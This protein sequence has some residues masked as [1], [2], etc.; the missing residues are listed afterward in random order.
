MHPQ[1]IIYVLLLV[2][3]ASASIAQW[4]SLSRGERFF[5]VLLMITVV[6]ETVAHVM[7]IVY[8][9]NLP[10]YH[11]YSPVELALTS[12]YLSDTTSF[13]HKR[14]MGYWIAGIAVG[15]GILNTT[16]FQPLE[17]FNTYYLLFESTIIIVLCLLSFYEM[18]LGEEG[19]P[20]RSAQ[21]WIVVFLLLYWSSTFFSWGVYNL[22]PSP[23][24]PRFAIIGTI[25]TAANMLFYAGVA[26]IFLSY[27]KL[28]Q[29][30]GR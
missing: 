3:A 9:N 20:Y 16:L 27:G 30:E 15:A 12:L 23:R 17:V 24:P 13:L 28:Q 4:K 11:F 6:Q 18:A 8:R 10:T 22:L 14:K 25:L 26:V 1:F 21:F 29:K 19:L 5:S 2:I 7:S